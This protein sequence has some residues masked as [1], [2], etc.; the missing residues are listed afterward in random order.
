V[1]ARRR[2]L[3]TIAVPIVV[4][5]L[6]VSFFTA[7]FLTTEGRERD[8]LLALVEHEARGDTPGVL[9]RLRS[10]DATCTAKVRAFVP[11]VSGVG[12][13]KIAR[14]DS[15]TAY[16]FGRSEGWSRIVWVRGVDGRPVVQCVRVLRKG[17]PLTDRSVSLLRV[18]APL[19]DNEDS[20]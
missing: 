9:T 7:R 6:V 20:C 8:A 11:R 13:V 18:T 17:S 4:V 10:C 19:A 3:L 2:R 5:F 15:G 1:L 16:S 14:L 12:A